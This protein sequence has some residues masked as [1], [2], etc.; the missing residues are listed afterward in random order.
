MFEP[1]E[2]AQEPQPPPRRRRWPARLR[3]AVRLAMLAVIM[4]AFLVGLDGCFYLPSNRLHYT[5]DQFGLAFETVSF[6]AAD[7]V[8]LSGWWLPARSQPAR[9]TVIHFHGNAENKSN[10]VALVTWLPPRGFNVLVWDYRGYGDSEGRVTRAGTI[11]DGHAALDYVLSRPDVDRWRVFVLGQSLGGA[12]ATV[13]AAERAEVAAVVVDS[14]FDSYRNI[15]ARH[16]QRTLPIPLLPRWLAQ[17]LLSGDYEPR[18]YVARISPRPLLVIAAPE[19]TICFPDLGRALYDAAGEPRRFLLLSRG[20]HLE[21]LIY[22][23]DD[24]QEQIA[25]FLDDAIAVE[26]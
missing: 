5:P 19:D 8:R 1:L 21:P 9:G 14:S 22:N 23:I 26:R 11:R 10:H 13:V 12:I 2:A 6:T 24:V 20:A 15:A 4:G 25:R 3:L 7:G 17:A 18:D 16:L